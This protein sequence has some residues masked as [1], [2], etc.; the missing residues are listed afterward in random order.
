MA[1][2]LELG[3][4]LRAARTTRRLYQ[5]DVAFAIGVSPA[6]YGVI[7]RGMNRPRPELLE[8]LAAYLALDLGELRRLAAYDLPPR[9]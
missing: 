9:G 6:T 5:R 8:R 7:E 3:E 4:R 2:W 1:V